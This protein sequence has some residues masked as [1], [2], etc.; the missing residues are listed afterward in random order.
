LFGQYFEKVKVLA[1]QSPWQLHA[2]C[3]SHEEELDELLE[4]NYYLH[5]GFLSIAQCIGVGWRDRAH[6][7]ATVAVLSILAY[8]AEKGGLPGSLAE[9]VTAGYLNSL[10]MDPYSDGPLV[11]KVVDDDFLLYSVGEDFTDDG[12]VYPVDDWDVFVGDY[13]FW[14]VPSEFD[15]MISDVAPEEGE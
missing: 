3:T 9:V 5:D 13:V 14:P 6:G 7:R 11:Y 10:P 15:D 8:Q 12:G 1:Q 4:G 2:A